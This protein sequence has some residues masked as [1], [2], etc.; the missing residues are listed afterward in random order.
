MS[1][2]RDVGVTDGKDPS[3]QSM[4]IASRDRTLDPA[5]RVSVPPGQLP[6]RDDP[7][8]PLRKLRQCLRFI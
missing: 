4:E 6:A 3:V 5:S 8:L 1:L 7:V 2:Q